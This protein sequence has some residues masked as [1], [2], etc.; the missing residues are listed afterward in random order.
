MRCGCDPGHQTASRLALSCRNTPCRCVPPANFTP[1][2]C[3]ATR[4]A[5]ARTSSRST[6]P[7]PMLQIDTYTLRVLQCLASA[8]HVSEIE[9]AADGHWRPAGTEGPWF[10]VQE[11]PKAVAAQLPTGVKP[12]PEGGPGWGAA[13]WVVVAGRGGVRWGRVGVGAW[14]AEGRGL[15][16]STERG[17]EGRGGERGSAGGGCASVWCCLLLRETRRSRPAKRPKSCCSVAPDW[18]FPTAVRLIGLAPL[19][20]TQHA[21]AAAGGPAADG[22][23]LSSDEEDE[24]EELRQAARAVAAQN[25]GLA[26]QVG[27]TGRVLSSAAGRS[28]CGVYSVAT[29]RCGALRMACAHAGAAGVGLGSVPVCAPAGAWQGLQGRA[30]CLPSP[31]PSIR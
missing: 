13:C 16:W 5:P 15:L 17:G 22:G 9:L 12:D 20:H 19:P 6:T 8:P 14:G 28:R 26:G 7:T 21:G 29:R 25:G 30:R 11:D 31:S 3:Y 23:V 2:G 10:S 24:E 4:P 1:V 27:A 18:E